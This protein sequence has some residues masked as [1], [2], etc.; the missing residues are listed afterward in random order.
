MSH[1]LLQLICHLLYGFLFGMLDKTRRLS[2]QNPKK[3]NETESTYTKSSIMKLFCTLNKKLS[4]AV[5]VVVNEQVQKWGIKVLSTE[6]QFAIYHFKSFKTFHRV[7]E[8][9]GQTT[10]YN[11]LSF[12]WWEIFRSNQLNSYKWCSR[13]VGCSLSTFTSAFKSCPTKTI[14]VQIILF[15]LFCLS[16]KS[17]MQRK[18]NCVISDLNWFI[19][20]GGKSHR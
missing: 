8:Q 11:A 14:K 4:V 12:I 16:A 19:Y 17:Q 1:F 10:I 13:A 7:H 15:A 3:M 6:E 9:S 5:A 2:I 18:T 20:M